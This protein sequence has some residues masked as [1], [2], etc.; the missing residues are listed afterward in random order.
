[1]KVTEQIDALETMGISPIAF[2]ATPRVLASI[3]MM[4]LLVI[5]ADVVAI[6]GAYFISNYFLGVSFNVFFLSVKRYFLFNDFM[7]G[8][9]KGMVFGGVTSMLGCHIG[10]RT[11]GGAEGVGLSTIR[12]FVISSALILILDYLLWTLIF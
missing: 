5:F 12:S 10:F 4:P 1:M 8:V 7:F 11:E 3:L 9:V 6:T 2:L